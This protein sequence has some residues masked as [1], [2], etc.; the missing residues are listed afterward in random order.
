MSGYSGGIE[1]RGP[2]T[3]PLRVT[4][5]KLRATPVEYNGP[6]PAEIKF[7]V[8]ITATGA[9][10]K[11]VCRILTSYNIP[12]PTMTISFEH[13]G[14]KDTTYSWRSEES[15]MGWQQLEIVEPNKLKSNRAE[16]SVM[17]ASP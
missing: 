8:K 13:A 16:F 4:K 2:E 11:V 9:P 17:C 15:M 7:Q 6:C 1:E 10:G 3:M 14:A 5:V 12:P